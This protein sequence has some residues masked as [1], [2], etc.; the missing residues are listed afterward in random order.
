[1]LKKSL[2][3]V[4]GE[5]FNRTLRDVLKRPVFEKIESNWIEILPKRTKQY[6]NR[7]HTSTKLAPTQS[8]LKKNEGFVYKSLLDKRKK[9]KPKFQVNDTIRTPDREKLFSYSDLTN[10]KYKIYKVTE[11]VNDIIP[12]YRIDKLP[13]CF[14]EALLKKTVLT[15]KDNDRVMNKL[16]LSSVEVSLTIR[17]YANQFIR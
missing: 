2:V 6:S 8:S 15:M 7:V 11:I 9:V 16:N 14:K 4:F 13:E 5:N 17:A 10:W 3:A 1:M 12:S